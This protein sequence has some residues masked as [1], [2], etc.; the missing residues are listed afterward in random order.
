[1]LRENAAHI[2]AWLP[3][4]LAA[5]AIALAAISIRAR[6][7]W[8]RVL[9]GVLLGFPL[10]ALAIALWPMRPLFRS[11]RALDSL[12][13]RPAPAIAFREVASG[14]Q[15]RIADYRGSVVVLNLWATWCPPCREELP[16]L[17]RLQAAY[18]DR[19]VVVVTLSDEPP[20]KLVELLARLAP[21]TVNGTVASFDWLRIESFRPFTVILD[22]DG[23]VGD[24]FFGS[25][26]YGAFER[27]VLARL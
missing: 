8:V 10:V 21:D 27:R 23:K 15:R 19:G 18:R 16:T 9:A 14:A 17:N 5:L 25:Q 11:A 3:W 13:G 2:A 1:M 24:Y 12:V 26:A 20:E 6:R 7:R 22:R 4:V